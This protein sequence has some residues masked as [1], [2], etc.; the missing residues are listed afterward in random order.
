MPRTVTKPYGE[1]ESI[2]GEVD[3][4]VVREDTQLD[5]RMLLAKVIEAPKEPPR[6]EGANAAERQYL[7]DLGSPEP[8]DSLADAIEGVRQDGNQSCTLIS[9]GQATRKSSEER[10]AQRIFKCL[11]LMAHRGLRH[12][13][14]QP[15]AGEAEMSCRGLEGLQ[16]IELEIGARHVDPQFFY[17]LGG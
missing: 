5:V 11:D 13:Q 4:V 1:V 10:G 9:E 16:G 17:G 14:F 7:V 6:R 15:G 2:S 12:P 3:A 8:L